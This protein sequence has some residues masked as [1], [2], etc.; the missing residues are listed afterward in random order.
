MK[1][2]KRRSADET[3]EEILDAAERR[4]SES[5]P[6]GIRLQDIAEQVGISH[7]A[8]LH[9]FGSREALVEAVVHRAIV[10]LQRELIGSISASGDAPP[11][12]AALFERVSESFAG[13][14][15]ARLM[16]WLV[17]SG[18]QPLGGKEMRENWSMIADA[19]HAMRPKSKGKPA[20]ED[21]LFTIVL[22]ALALFGQAILGQTTF[23]AAGLPK[24][25][26]TQKRFRIWLA[27]LLASH[28]A[29]T[30]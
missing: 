25:A 6:A 28:L 15:H 11:D 18:Y 7:P 5:G 24:D 14:G 19:M 12:G 9:H 21:T 4:F 1:T 10:Q 22:S 2:R 29:A 17:L 27:S 20:R 8:V 3:K 23:E 16:A 26:A 13:A 30:D